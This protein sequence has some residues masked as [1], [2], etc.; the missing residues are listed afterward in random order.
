MT[1]RLTEIFNN[2]QSTHPDLVAGASPLN[3]GSWGIVTD[4]NDGTVTKFLFRQG[5]QLQQNWAQANLNNELAF[6]RLM[7]GE[8]FNGVDIPAL[9][10][11]VTQVD[12]GDFFAFYRMTKLS[13]VAADWKSGTAKDAHFFEAGQ[14]LAHFHAA[15]ADLKNTGLIV[16]DIERG[17]QVESVPGLDDKRNA[18]LAR[19]NNYLQA[20]KQSGIIHADYH[21]G[22]ILLND[23]GAIS[24]LVD[25]AVTGL[26]EN[27]A[28][29]FINVPEEKR[30]AFIKGYEQ[31]SGKPVDLLMITMT[32]ISY[33]ASCLNYYADPDQ[34]KT[35]TDSLDR[36]LVT[37]S[38]IT[39]YSPS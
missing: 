5:I 27:L 28:S 6:L 36:H 3:A 38:S 14:K 17:G 9:I 21:G 4:H 7:K 15:T 16:H 18:A 19:A 1:D 24:G 35:Y 32:E 23:K 30:P 34:L 26:S 33:L 22:N 29:D 39:G 25:F 37:A 10:C 31:A 8:S 2:L 13:G 20:H 12:K 11:D